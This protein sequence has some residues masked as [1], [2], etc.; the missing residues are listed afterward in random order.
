VIEDIDVC[1]VVC[2][3]ILADYYTFY[4]NLLFLKGD[5]ASGHT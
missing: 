1:V 4:V 2:P 3:K 5:E